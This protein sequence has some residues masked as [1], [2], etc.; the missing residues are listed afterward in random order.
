ST[1]LI[2]V[3]MMV[4]LMRSS[5][6]M[7][8][9][10]PNFFEIDLKSMGNALDAVVV[11]KSVVEVVPVVG[12][13]LFSAIVFSSLVV[14]A[15]VELVLFSVSVSSFL[16]FLVFLFSDFFELMILYSPSAIISSKSSSEKI[17]PK[18]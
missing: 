14:V 15:V 4:L 5:C 6:K 12:L 10:I 18:G 1:H 13:V 8:M 3:P 9:S 11:V 2:A 16:D 7:P 17:K